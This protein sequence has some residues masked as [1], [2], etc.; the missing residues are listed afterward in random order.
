M[1]KYN[2]ILFFLAFSSCF[3]ISC[4]KET[5]IDHNLPIFEK[6]DGNYNIISAFSDRPYDINMDGSSSTDM[7]SE[8]PNLERSDI[9]IVVNKQNR[10]FSLLWIE[11][12]ENVEINLSSA[13]FSYNKQGVSNYFDTDEDLNSIFLKKNLDQDIRFNS[14]NSINTQEPNVIKIEITKNIITSTGKQ[15]ILINAIYK[16]NK[17]YKT[18]YK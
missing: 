16:R 7:L 8:I 12:Y 13:R 17:D 5:E 11:Q 10:I 14:P 3:A 18:T 2:Y 1:K 15:T 4:K 9:N 6:L